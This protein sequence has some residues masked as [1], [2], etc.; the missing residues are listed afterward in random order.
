VQGIPSAFIL[1]AQQ[2]R[3]RAEALR[4]GRKRD[5]ENVSS[6]DNCESANRVRSLDQ[7]QRIMYPTLRSASQ[8]KPPLPASLR[9]VGA[10]CRD[11]NVHGLGNS[12]LRSLT[13]IDRK[14][15]LPP[16]LRDFVFSGDLD[17]FADVPSIPI[18]CPCEP[19]PSLDRPT[20]GR[21][22]LERDELSDQVDAVGMLS[23]SKFGSGERS[24]AQHWGEGNTESKVQQSHSVLFRL[25]WC[26]GSV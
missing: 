11:N 15:H 25:M 13:P 8:E 16:H 14:A 24:W 20:Q 18:I 7:N 1:R 26:C 9:N 2:W 17:V 5:H 6:R 4:D 22:G 12:E 21:E 3:E 10:Q 19:E 23:R